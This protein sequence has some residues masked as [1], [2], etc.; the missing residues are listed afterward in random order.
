VHVMEAG[1]VKRS[2]SGVVIQAIGGATPVSY[3]VTNEHVVEKAGLGEPNFQVLVDSHGSTQVYPATVVA[4]GKIPAMDLA[5]LRVAGVAL[6]PAKLA[7]D[8]EVAVGDDVVV[9]GAPYGKGLS[10]SHGMLSQVE[11]SAGEPAMLKTDAPVGYG[12]SGGGIYDLQTGHLLGVVEGYRTAQVQI[13]AETG[14]AGGW[15]FDVPMPG[16]TFASSVAKVRHF[17]AEKGVAHPG[18]EAVAARR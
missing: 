12:A 9:V 16:E 3:I 11:L 15:T 5:V 18:H 10:I 13:P 7:T 2:A 8:D 6:H 14:S 17:F 4:E 1:E